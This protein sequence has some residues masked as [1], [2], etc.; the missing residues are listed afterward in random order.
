[1]RYAQVAY[2][3]MAIVIEK[4]NKKNGNNSTKHAHKKREIYR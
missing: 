3:N 2:L 4:R 1:M